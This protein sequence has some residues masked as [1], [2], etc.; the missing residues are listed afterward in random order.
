MMPPQGEKSNSSNPVAA[1]VRITNNAALL[2][3]L[4]RYV[5]CRKGNLR[6][7][8]YAGGNEYVSHKRLWEK[9]MIRLKAMLYV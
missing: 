5:L 2:A 1:V 6:N 9:P 7:G 4:G 8:E 3:N